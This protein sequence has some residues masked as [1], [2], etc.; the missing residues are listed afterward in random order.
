MPSTHD[1]A[2]DLADDHE[3]VAAYGDAT[4]EPREDRLPW[5]AWIRVATLLL[6]LVS[7]IG[8]A[9]C[10]AIAVHKQD[11]DFFLGSALGG[12]MLAAVLLLWRFGHQPAAER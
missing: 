10:L 9:V 6:L 12:I 11:F 4:P 2:T 3:P 5:A 7:G 1:K 8:D